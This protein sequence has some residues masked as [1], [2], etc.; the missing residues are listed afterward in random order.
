MVEFV[1]RQDSRKIVTNTPSGRN[2]YFVA[3]NPLGVE[4]ADQE[5]FRSQDEIYEEVKSKSK[6]KVKWEESKEAPPSPSP[7]PIEEKASENGEYDLD[8][9]STDEI[10]EDEMFAKKA[11]GPWTC[12]VCGEKGLKTKKAVRSHVGSKKCV[13]K[14][15]KNAK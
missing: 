7:P 9:L 3:G 2:Y 14:A 13:N 8:A 11:K 1:L 10:I 6:P 5:F 15:K 12:P 4:K